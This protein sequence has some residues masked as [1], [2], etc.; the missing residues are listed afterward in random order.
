[1]RAAA[2]LGGIHYTHAKKAGFTHYGLPLQGLYPM[3]ELPDY[4]ALLS[5]ALAFISEMKFRKPVRRSFL[6]I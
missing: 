3:K 1:M 2:L 5:L 4:I 6:G